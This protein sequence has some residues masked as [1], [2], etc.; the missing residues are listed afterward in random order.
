MFCIMLV[1]LI[2]CSQQGYVVFKDYKKVMNKLVNVDKM[3]LKLCN[4]DKMFGFFMVVVCQ[5]DVL[6]VVKVLLFVEIEG[7]ICSDE[8]WLLFVVIKIFVG[9]QSYWEGELL[10]GFDDVYVDEINKD[11]VVV[12]YEGMK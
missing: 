12:Q 10:V 2:F 6:V 11:N 4:S 9:Q 3:L 5:V 8:L 7:I 1:M